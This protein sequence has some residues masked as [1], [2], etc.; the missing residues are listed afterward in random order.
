[1]SIGWHL[2]TL[3]ALSVC[4][5]AMEADAVCV[6]Q[7]M[8]SRPIIVG[9]LFGAA[10]GAPFAG[11]ALG[12]VFEAISLE[13]APVGSFIPMNGAVAAA[14]AVML[15]AGPD[16]LPPAAAL[17]AG[18][19]AGLAATRVEKIFRDHR[20]RL[21]AEAAALLEEGRG[22]PWSSFLIRSAGGYA[23]AVAALIYLA[24]A[25]LGPAVGGLLDLLPAAARMGMTTAFNWAPWLALGI[26]MHSLA[27]GK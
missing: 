18:W 19:A 25:A 12:A 4:A 5:A 7:W 3:P 23:A 26:L 20:A 6:G 9:P 1:M 15:S 14:C 10:L 13:A 16:M 8:L 11:A 17:P 22:V 24:V 27:R 21:S 2:L